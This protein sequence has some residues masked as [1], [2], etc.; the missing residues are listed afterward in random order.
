ML[1]KLANSCRCIRSLIGMF[2]RIE[3]SHENVFRSRMKRICPKLPGVRFG[4]M[5]IGDGRIDEVPP[6]HRCRTG[7]VRVVGSREHG[8]AHDQDAGR[9]EPEAIEHL[10]PNVIRGRHHDGG[11]AG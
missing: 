10:L 9:I 8:R 4:T 7:A 3:V 1:L 6:L 11:G 2:L 5:P